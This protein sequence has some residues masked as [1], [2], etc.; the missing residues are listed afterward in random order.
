MILLRQSPERNE[1]PAKGVAWAQLAPAFRRPCWRH[2]TETNFL[3]NYG[4]IHWEALTTKRYADERC[5]PECVINPH[6]GLT[7]GGIFWDV[8]SCHWRST[9]LRTVGNFNSNKY[10][11][12]LLQLQVI[13]S[14]KA[15]LELSF[16][17]IIHAHMLQRLFE[18]WNLVGW[19]L[20]RDPCPTASKDELLL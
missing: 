18:T 2:S 3:L 13:P 12:E 6:S 16:S 8:I 1:A 19:R 20:A 7:P 15:S 11:C 10:F 4:P 14:F 17:R 9:L 5:L